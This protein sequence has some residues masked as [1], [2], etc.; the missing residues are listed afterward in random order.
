DTNTAQSRLIDLLAG[1]HQNVMVVGD[2]DQSIYKFRG[3]AVANI[4]QFKD[5][6]PEAKQLALLENYRSGQAI[7]DSAYRLIQ[8][9]N[10]DRLEARYGLNKR[11]VS[12]FR[13]SK[14][15]L[16]TFLT[17]EDETQWI[18]RDIKRQIKQGQVA[19]EI[20]VLLRRNDQARILEKYLQTENLPYVIIGE[21]K[22]L[23]RQAEVK[24]LLSFLRVVCDPK[25]SQS[26]YHL[27]VSD[28]YG[29]KPSWLREQVA[30][31]ERQHQTLEK[32]LSEHDTKGRDKQIHLVAGFFDQLERWREVLPKLSVGKLCYRFLED[33][34]YLHKLMK[35]AQDDPAIDAQ[36]A[37]L[38][39]YFMNLLE[40]ERVASDD[41]AVGYLSNLPTLLGT[42]ER[43]EVE[44]L[45]DV[46]GQKVR[47]LTMHK[48]KGLEFTTV[49][50]FDQTQDSFPARRQ[51]E[52]LE[53]PDQLLPK[54]TG[55][56]D[57]HLQEE[58]RL[59]Y[60]AMTRAK[61]NL[62]LTCS[63]DHGGRSPKRPS[64]F[65]EEA[66]GVRPELKTLLPARAHTNQ[67]ELFKPAKRIHKRPELPP[68]LIQGKRL[69]LTTKQIEDYLM[70]PAEFRLRHILAPPQPPLFAL[71]YGSLIH[72]LIQLYNRL[73]R[74]KQPAKLSQLQSYLKQ[75]WP[76]EGFISQAH[77]RRSLKQAQ[78]TLKRYFEREQKAKR[79]PRFIEQ[80]FELE[81][82]E[83]KLVVHG[84]FDAVYEDRQ[85]I[86][87]RD[88]KSG[89]SGVTT[90]ERADKRANENLQLGIY[91]LAWLRLHKER[92]D[93]VSLDFVDS[94]FIGT[95]HKTDRQLESLLKK[96]T[97]AV[98]G[99]R[100]GDF[101]P[102]GSHIFCSHQE[103]GF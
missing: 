61:K 41:S 57:V 102:S 69:V 10:P 23:Y 67:I 46:Y 48:A 66:L 51:P 77:S 6:Y 78:A 24:L 76:K 27:L 31:A 68:T 85:G 40:Y 58:R 52:P 32:T 3:A 16:K 47:L 19:S 7:L 64:I 86:E 56:E 8:Y 21:T 55:L 4:L 13:G 28:V 95:A 62:I 89:A 84:R 88:Y 79:H 18:A 103:Y 96:I 82:P 38:N 100:K 29:I 34:K 97:G 73:Q 30:V 2:D 92:P 83:L 74:D 93:I 11:L 49:Y 44:D 15:R 33:T 98:A 36:I 63:V 60:V 101:S 25:D 37:N 22:D 94:G 53:V 87:I 5:R 12:R 80:S 75:N 42:G 17:Y 39:Q 70:C 71:E 43:L 14:P 81:L 91:A 65:I 59:M 54:D 26:L 45:P 9:N 20:A 90:Q 35:Q 99:I 1:Q 72:S 50:L